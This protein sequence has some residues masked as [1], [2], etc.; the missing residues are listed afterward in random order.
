MNSRRL[1]LLVVIGRCSLWRAWSYAVVEP[2]QLAAP[3]LTMYAVQST[4]AAR[5]KTV[6]PVRPG[7]FTTRGQNWLCRPTRGSCLA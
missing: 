3:L 7:P 1:A 2:C 5:I 4:R 6:R